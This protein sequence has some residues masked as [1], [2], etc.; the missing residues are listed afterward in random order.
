MGV[1]GNGGTGIYGTIHHVVLGGSR[2][3]GA[4]YGEQSK[5]RPSNG[6]AFGTRTSAG[7]FLCLMDVCGTVGGRCRALMLWHDYLAVRGPASLGAIS[8]R[9]VLYCRPGGVKNH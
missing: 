7:A 9:G 6:R 1:G 5:C 2:S 3:C 8:N 4:L